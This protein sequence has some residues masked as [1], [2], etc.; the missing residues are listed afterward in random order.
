MG[1]RRSTGKHVKAGGYAIV[2]SSYL[3]SQAS[4]LDFA[5][6]GGES[7]SEIGCYDTASSR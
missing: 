6:L 5:S 4:F 7:G 1:R 3:I 2:S